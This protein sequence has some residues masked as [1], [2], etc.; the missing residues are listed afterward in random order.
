MEHGTHSK[1]EHVANCP[2]CE[3][4]LAD[5]QCMELGCDR[6]DRRVKRMT[7]GVMC[8]TCVSKLPTGPIKMIVTRDDYF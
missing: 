4:A 5:G 8:Y 1:L 3:Q 6:T 2:I 7:R